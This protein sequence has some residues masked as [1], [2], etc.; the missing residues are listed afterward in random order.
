MTT[1][2]RGIDRDAGR[3]TLLQRAAGLLAGGVAL[4]GASRWATAAPSP[5]AAPR[6]T[7][8][9]Y[10]RLR[11]ASVQPDAHGRLVASGDLLDR[12]DGECI[13]SFFSNAFCAA[14]PFGGPQAADS[15]LAFHVLQLHDGT[16]FS[17]G[18]GL[19]TPGGTV[20]AIVGGTHRFA[21]R[22]GSYVQR[23]IGSTIGDDLRE[24]TI[25]FAH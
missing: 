14:S 20:L 3:R 2:S 22:S 23:S 9:L 7:L 19:D 15:N 24:L 18:S 12:P 4:A 13:G 25:T 10:A 8:T 21:G 6:G 17:I 1:G 11:P 5:R 16:L